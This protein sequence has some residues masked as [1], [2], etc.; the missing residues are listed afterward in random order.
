MARGDPA[1]GIG[2]PAPPLAHRAG[3]TPA[4][5]GSRQPAPPRAGARAHL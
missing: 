5:C 2:A 4:P 3:P 1:A